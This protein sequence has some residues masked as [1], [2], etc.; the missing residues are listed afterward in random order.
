MTWNRERLKPED[1]GKDNLV[2][3]CGAGLWPA[4]L[5]LLT[6]ER[7]LQDNHLPRNLMERKVAAILHADVQG[8]SRLIEKDEIGTLQV[9]TPYLQMMTELVQ[10]HG[11]HPVG[12]RGDSLLA[13]FPSVI[14][15]VQCAVELQHELKTRNTALP[16]ERQIHFRMGINLGE[17]VSENGQLHGDGI[18]IAVRLE[19]LAD[20]GG[21]LI[22]GTVYDQVEHK[23]PFRYEYLGEQQ[24]KNISKPVRAYR[25]I[26]DETESPQSRVHSAKAKGAS[27]KPRKVSTNVFVS[28]LVFVLVV[29][30]II[31]VRYFPV[32]PPSTQ[33]LAPSPQS[34]T[35]NPQPLPLPDKPSIVVLPFVNMSGDPEQE[36]FSDGLTEDLTSAL[37]RLSG[38]FVIS[39]NTAFFYKGKAVKLPELSKELGVQYVLEGSVRRADG[40]V[41]ITTQLIDATQDHH[42]WSERYDRS[43]KDIFVLQDEIVQKIVTTLKL[44]L[45]LWEQGVLVRKTTDNL[46]AY[47][48]Y[49]RGMESAL[50]AYY[51]T[52]KQAN[53]QA[54][55]LLEKAIE[56]DPAYAEAYVGL[57]LTYFYDGFYRW[58]PDRTQSFDQALELLQ[59]AIALDDSLPLAHQLLSGVYVW[60]KKQHDRAIAEAERAVALDPNNA[61]GY[62][63]L[64]SALTWAGRAEEGIGLMEKAMRLNPRYPPM[65]LQGL[66]F[67]YR[68]AGRYEEAIAPAKKLL[69]LNPNFAP[70][71][72]QLASCYAHLGRLEEAR[73]EA[74]EVMR[75]SPQF[76]LE[77]IRQNLPIKDPAI[78][79]REI[80]AW[81]KAGLK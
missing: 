68:L 52:N 78:L 7:S 9:L 35:P 69:V 4:L 14:E 25:I 34:L 13:E 26:Q 22:S 53:V 67:A 18:N 43:L 5:C 6:A 17:V 36:Y 46:E 79:E 37:S 71:H 15:A 10:H 65:Y 8:Y 11:G 39:R 72:L 58:S 61:D 80:D 50:R 75:L 19:S 60:E 33:S 45:S 76:S 74:A 64:G 62:V 32:S 57:G 20:A 56:L 24:V 12:S 70:A 63:N 44:Q 3:S 73:A 21:I 66:N 16:P 30:G 77:E 55:Q 23:L 47:D 81:R 29:A 31:A 2:R 41:R 51:G 38:L 49:L 54:Q 40:Q 1:L 48:F 27:A 59:K 42:L 28:V